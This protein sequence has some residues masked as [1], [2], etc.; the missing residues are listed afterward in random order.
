MT[1]FS[2]EQKIDAMLSRVERYRSFQLI[3]SDGRIAYPMAIQIA[4][5]ATPEDVGVHTSLRAVALDMHEAG[6]LS[7]YELPLGKF[8]AAVNKAM[9]EHIG[10]MVQADDFVDIARML[11]QTSTKGVNNLLDGIRYCGWSSSLERQVASIDWEKVAF[12]MYP[13]LNAMRDDELPCS[14]FRAKRNMIMGT[15]DMI[16]PALI[17][18]MHGTYHIDTVVRA[19]R[20][21]KEGKT[22][23]A[24]KMLNLDGALTHATMRP[25]ENIP[26]HA[27]L[28]DGHSV[29]ASLKVFGKVDSF[30][31][32][33]TN[34]YGDA[35]RLF[36]ADAV[37]LYSA[38]RRE[39]NGVMA[40]HGCHVSAIA[41]ND[42][43]ALCK[44]GIGMDTISELVW[45]GMIT[46]IDDL[47]SIAARW[48]GDGITIGQAAFLV[49]EYVDN[50]PFAESTMPDVV[51]EH[52]GWILRRMPKSS[53]LQFAV[54]DFASCCQHIG[55]ASD[56]L[57]A[58]IPFYD[59]VDNYYV[60]SPNGTCIADMVIWRTIHGDY[61][62]DSI[63]GKSIATDQL[64][65]KFVMD[66]ASAVEG[67]LYISAS[68]YGV[69]E[70]VC[71]LIAHS[72]LLLAPESETSLPYTDTDDGVYL[73]LTD[74][75]IYDY[76]P[77]PR[78][79]T[80]RNGRGK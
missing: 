67:K 12:W 52:D 73:V 24:A 55:G 29:A 48:D 31:V 43:V 26:Y 27:T 37:D 62:I 19:Y 7:R 71:S 35:K 34:Y 21:A 58:H 77:I 33:I 60:S 65:A 3:S 20:T 46:D 11:G 75:E 64:M 36:S 59:G 16:N 41:P 23:L 50:K 39:C 4:E 13:E 9:A 5:D 61:V 79:G 6:R 63:E 54:G 45:Y 44:D 32:A 25:N 18:H 72:K 10:P 80:A 8:V 1:M 69:T 57:L 53:P 15:I 76:S 22:R 56:G 14:L 42:F 40:H 28:M 68:C 74:D 78:R 66:I 38:L 47:R 51:S 49:E 70:G 30:V 17:A 2:H